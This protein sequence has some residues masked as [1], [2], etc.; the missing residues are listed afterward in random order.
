[1]CEARRNGI[2]DPS[3]IVDT[4]REIRYLKPFK[5]SKKFSQVLQFTILDLIETQFNLEVW[6][7]QKCFPVIVLEKFALGEI[8]EEITRT[9]HVPLIV[10]R[11]FTSDAKLFELSTLIPQNKEIVFQ[12]YSDYDDSGMHMYYSLPRT[13]QHYISNPFR[14]EIGALTLTQIQKYNLQTIPKYYKKSGL[15]KLICELDAL[16]PNDLKQIVKDNIEKLIDNKPMFKKRLKDLERERKKLKNIYIKAL[17][18]I[19]IP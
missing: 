12:T 14:V 18:N 3:M 5:D 8:L 4:S 10:N 17:K 19:N 9:Y 2:I 13:A 11:G 6:Q 15:T 1:L 16:N 7:D